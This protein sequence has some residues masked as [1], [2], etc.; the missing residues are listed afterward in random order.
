MASSRPVSWLL[1]IHGTAKRSF[2]DRAHARSSFICRANATSSVNNQVLS[3]ILS[4]CYG[5]AVTNAM[6]RIA[7]RRRL[8]TNVAR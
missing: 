7:S 4:R 3:R 1:G 6:Y 8:H 2:L 5:P